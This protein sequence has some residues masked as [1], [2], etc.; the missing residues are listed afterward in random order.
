MRSFFVV[1]IKNRYNRR[2]ERVNVIKLLIYPKCSTCKKAMQWL[3]DNGINYETRHLI[4]D[5]LSVNELKEIHMKLNL[6]IKKLFN[7]SG[8]K[9][10]ELE[11]KNKIPRLSTEELYKLLAS[12]GMLVKR[13]LAI[14][15]NKIVLGFNPSQYESEWL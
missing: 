8:V 1:A 10:R 11:L 7:T 6:P 9:Y 14:D 3:D 2:E 12:D 15:A 4:E 5:S 13:P